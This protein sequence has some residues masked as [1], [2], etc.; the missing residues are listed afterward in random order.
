MVIVDRSVAKL[1]WLHSGLPSCIA[2]RLG[3]RVKIVVEP[4]DVFGCHVLPASDFAVVVQ[5]HHQWMVVLFGAIAEIEK[6]NLLLYPVEER[7]AVI[8]YVNHL[9]YLATDIS[10]VDG[11]IILYARIHAREY[12]TVYNSQPFVQFL[13]SVAVDDLTGHE[14]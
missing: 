3:E 10:G 7:G 11:H 14:L 9:P 2:D 13:G 12:L 4:A 5:S 1:L 8:L 6:R